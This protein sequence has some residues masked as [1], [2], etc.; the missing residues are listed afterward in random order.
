[1]DFSLNNDIYNSIIAND[2]DYFF[3]LS[4]LYN[5]RLL[6]FNKNH[7]YPFSSVLNYS[8][9]DQLFQH[10]NIKLVYED[11]GIHIY[12]IINTDNKHILRSIKNYSKIHVTRF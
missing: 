7:L 9:L 12:E 2:Y 5:L 11:N 8:H 1:M 6:Y 3:Y 10:E 4:S